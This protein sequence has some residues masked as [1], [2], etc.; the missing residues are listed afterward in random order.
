MYV[1]LPTSRTYEI[2]KCITC[3]TK[4]VMYMLQCSCNTICIGKTSRAL[5]VRLG[6][7]KSTIRRQEITLPVARHF[8]EQRSINELRCVGI[9]TVHPPRRDDDYD[10]KLL[11]REAM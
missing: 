7:H 10:N 11:K 4:G 6:E 8:I 2:K 9:E 5:K 1:C 3:T